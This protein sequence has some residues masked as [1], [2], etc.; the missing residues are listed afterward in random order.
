MYRQ[1]AV[2]QY[3]QANK[4]GLKYYKNAVNHGSYPYPKVLDEL[5]RENQSAGRV[6]LGLVDIPSELIVGTM[7]AGRREAFAGNFMPLLG[8]DTEFGR[9]WISLCSAHLGDEGI[10][11]PIRCCEYL[12][13]FYVVEGNK[14]V[15][16]LK[17]Y[18]APTI[19]GYVTRVLPVY[20]EDPEVQLYYEFLHFYSRCSLYQIRFTKPGS[21]DKLQKRMGYDKDHVWTLDEKRSFLSLLNRFQSICLKH[22]GR[23]LSG[24]VSDVLLACLQV[25]S[26]EELKAK[27]GDELEKTIDAMWADV[28]A[29]PAPRDIA[30][31]TAPQEEDQ[32][33][34]GKILGITRPDH[35]NIAFIYG[36]DPELSAWTR[37]HMQGKKTLARELEGKVTIQ[38]YWALKHDYQQAMERAAADGANVIF[39]TTPQMIGDCRKIAALNP[40]LR[41]LNCALSKPYLGLR[42]YYSRSYEAKFVTGAIAGAMA[43]TDRI[44]YIANYPI[45]GVPADINAFALGAQMTNPRARIELL[46]SSE[47]D[48]PLSIFRERGISVISN[49]DATDQRKGQW[50]LDFGSN[51]L[52][53]DGSRIPLATPRWD[54]GRFYV[55]VVRSMF[56]GSYDALA[57]SQGEQAINYWWGM[58]GGLIEVQLSPAL[59]EGLKRLAEHLCRDLRD[60]WFEP[61]RCHILDQSGLLRN[62]GENS[63]SPAEIMRMDWL[64]E[65]VEGHIPEIQELKPEA[66]GTS[67]VL[68]IK[69]ENVVEKETDA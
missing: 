12:G 24:T 29:A 13:Y 4:L 62:D 51:L 41:V 48:D 22:E 17:S 68:A 34:F 57:K 38:D 33:L 69:P 44:G 60:G 65:N 43:E 30:V 11:D 50:A 26:F 61:F 47:T 32:S 5:L 3:N 28:N 55:Q 66:V 37:A 20:S 49:R 45:V 7:A 21:Y 19:P 15:S 31:S 54:W 2:L 18:D 1:E 14:R 53:V 42:T 10:R 6:E 40:K 35:L 59:P 67:Q 9:K 27:T 63:L 36:N 58:N 39:A 25:F 52:N 16:V 64:C 23:S 56:N 46:W 8:P